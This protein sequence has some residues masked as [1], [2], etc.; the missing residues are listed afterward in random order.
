MADSSGEPMDIGMHAGRS[1]SRVILTCL[2]GL[3]ALVIGALPLGAQDE[4]EL[5]GVQLAAE[6]AD[7][8]EW[9]DPATERGLL[10]DDLAPVPEVDLVALHTSPVFATGVD[11]V[12]VEDDLLTD[13]LDRHERAL[14][15]AATVELAIDETSSRI[16]GLRP[17]VERL[18][19]D[20]T[21][22]IDEEARLTREIDQITA[23]IA[24]FAVRAFIGDE[25]LDT[26]FSE[27]VNDLG[28]TQVLADGV[29]DAQFDDIESKEAE[30][31]EHQADRRRDEAERDELRTTIDALQQERLDQIADLRSLQELVDATAQSYHRDLH[32]HL[33]HTVEGADFQLVAL[34][35]Y[36]IAS[37]TLAETSPECAI[38]WWMLAGIGSIESFHGQIHGS[39]LDINADTTE[40][41]FGP[42]LDG[43]ILSGEEFVTA[44]SD[45]PAATGR[46]EDLPVAD[47]APAVD[48]SAGADTDAAADGG[49]ADGE[50]DGEGGADAPVIRRLALIEDTDGGLLDEDTT[51][52][53]AVGPMQF[54]PQTWALQEIDAN[55]D[56]DTNPQNLYDAALASANYLC[57][58][59]T[60]MTTIEGQEQAYFAYNHDDAYTAAVIA[61]SEEYR[62]LVSLPTDNPNAEGAAGAATDDLDEPSAIDDADTQGTR[63]L[64]IGEHDPEQPVLAE[65]DPGL[66][67]W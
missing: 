47:A 56:G 31:A 48:P 66:P 60:T 10:E 29:R 51:Y 19:V 40:S 35:A 50:A 7:S 20:I 42:A 67:D 37:R 23:A 27:P 36:V 17:Q 53:R 9:T 26:A 45:V 34:N 3:L 15:V 43:R 32:T 8:S 62:D 58:S 54:I 61:A 49:A 52:D 5:H 65:T 11:L 2:T 12:P 24:E 59:T 39:T 38:E 57:Q 44:G 6:A 18:N 13:A 28:E 21:V 4:P 63:W 30:R 25:E 46:T 33:T 22:A 1:H 55:N 41:I 14:Q 16:D 64:G